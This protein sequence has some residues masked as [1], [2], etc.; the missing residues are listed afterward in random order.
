MTTPTEFPEFAIT[1]TT[2]SGGSQNKIILPDTLKNIGYE[3][4]QTPA[5]QHFNWLFNNI[6]KWIKD[7]NER[8]NSAAGGILTMPDIYPVGSMY[9]NA[10]NTTNPAT[11]LGFGTWVSMGSG[12]M[13]MGSGSYTDAN[14]ETRIVNTNTPD[15]GTYRHTTTVDEMP[16]H[17]HG[18]KLSHERGGSKDSFGYPAVDATG[19]L[20]THESTEADGSS[21][22]LSGDGNPLYSTGGNQPHNNTPPFIVVNIWQR[23]A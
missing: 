6:Y 19:P 9:F 15:T 3:V 2:L 11:L 12:R 1:D 21:S 4:D 18:I 8:L 22:S 7:L 14:G 10:S 16:T 13:I 17:K 23:T 20:I 5:P